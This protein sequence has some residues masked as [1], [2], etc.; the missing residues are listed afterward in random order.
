MFSPHF[1]VGLPAPHTKTSPKSHFSSSLPGSVGRS[2]LTWHLPTRAWASTSLIVDEPHQGD[3]LITHEQRHPRATLP[4]V[5]LQ[6]EYRRL[7]RL[8][9]CDCGSSPIVSPPR[10]RDQS[11]NPQAP[12]ERPHRYSPGPGGCCLCS[13]RGLDKVV[14]DSV[15]KETGLS[16]PSKSL[17]RA[18]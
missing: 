7:P 2:L 9:Q 5:S 11:L 13:P 18:A 6:D 4:T 8:Q 15:G 16:R 1:N 3:T 17:A 14:F 10:P 12:L